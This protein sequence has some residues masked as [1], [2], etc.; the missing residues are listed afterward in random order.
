MRN[1]TLLHFATSLV[2][3][4]TLPLITACS[5]LQDEAPYRQRATAWPESVETEA[6]SSE[7]TISS[8]VDGLLPMAMPSTQALDAIRAPS[9]G[10]EREQYAEI[11]D[12]PVRSVREHPVS[13]FSIDVDTG[14]Y[15][16]VRR[17][18]NQGRL[19]P[20]DAV[21][22]EELVNYFDYRYAPPASRNPPF[23]IITELSATPWN[24]NTHL[25]KIALQ[26]FRVARDQR[27]AVNL[28]FL[29]AVSG[30][31]DSPDKLP[32]LKSA[33]GLLVSQL[34]ERDRVSIVVY[35]GA[36]GVVLEPTSGSQKATIL[37]A[38]DRLSAGGSTHGSAGLELA[39]AMVEQ[40]RIPGGINRVLLATDG[41]FNVG[42][43]NHEQL[44]D[45]IERKRSTGISLTTL[46]FGQGN[47][48]D[49]L[50]EQL[51]D[52]GD[53]NYAYIDTISEAQKL[54]VEELSATLETIAR[55]VKIQIEFN[56][57]LVAEYRLIGYEN[58]I[59][60]REDFGNDRVDAGDIGAGHSVT[61]LYEIALVAGGQRRL[62]PLRYA[63]PRQA[64]PSR[65]GQPD[66]IAFLRLRFK[67]PGSDASQLIERPVLRSD[68]VENL[69]QTSE[70]FR[71]AAAVA[72]FGQSLRGGK[73]LEGFT[74]DNA[75]ELARG[76]RGEDAYGYRGE[77]LRLVQLAQSLQTAS[78]EQRSD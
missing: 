42:T 26:G 24:P 73:Y 66:E 67:L 7:A 11:Q 40:A 38:L 64:E 76:A 50:M 49:R 54:L 28:V 16:V 4:F 72:A 60:S 46:G 45:L 12:N 51:A 30:S 1:P 17:Y 56:P 75:A 59:L 19:P 15:A 13:T 27:P 68:L 22:V 58:R 18:L 41:D 52:H 53:G 6:L 70:D 8:Q 71:F 34:G 37:A 2:V 36:S 31:M 10:V 20:S 63:E 57:A 47:Y 14:S 39:Y 61:A 55:D 77:F 21:R 3:A 74:L 43:V 32:L 33:L 29:L 9:T 78:R 23:H 69:A 62:E 25:L 5:Y 44:I 65:A 35:A 48:N